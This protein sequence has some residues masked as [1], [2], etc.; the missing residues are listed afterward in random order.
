MCYDIKASLETQLKRAKRNND[1]VAITEIIEK[2]GPQTQLPLFHASGYSHPKLFVYTN[3]QAALPIVAAWGL[4]PHWSKDIEQAKK[5]WNNTLNARG[6]TIYEKP[7]FRSSAKSKRCII[8]VDGFFEHHYFNKKTFPYFIHKKEKEAIIL[9]GLY[10]E[11]VDK[12]TGEIVNTFTIVTTKGNA[13]L[14]KIHNNPKLKEPRMPVLLNEEEATI[15]LNE[16]SS[17]NEIESLIKPYAT[18]D[19]E[20]YTVHALR[21][22]NALGNVPDASKPEVYK[23]LAA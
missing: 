19:L 3:A 23:E 21:G 9:A 15:W 5:F 8:Y 13:L 7:S 17:K 16:K 18:D 1:E 12:N 20:A 10:D 22:K 2:L 14:S 4:I 11:W 6:E